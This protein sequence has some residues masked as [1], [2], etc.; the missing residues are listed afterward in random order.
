M[1]YGIEIT[2]QIHAVWTEQNVQIEGFWS[3]EP[4]RYWACCP[5]SLCFEGPQSSWVPKALRNSPEWLS[6]TVSAQPCQSILGS[7]GTCSS[8]PH[9]LCVWLIP[10]CLW[11]RNWSSTLF[12]IENDHVCSCGCLALWAALT[13]A[14]TAAQI[15]GGIPVCVWVIQ[16]QSY[17]QDTFPAAIHGKVLFFPLI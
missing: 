3:A 10:L 13:A 6:S 11:T 12:L 4:S 7:L 15:W 14:V 5:A 16:K 8:S 2:D 1:Y 9:E 17:I